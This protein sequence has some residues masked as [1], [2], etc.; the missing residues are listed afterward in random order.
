MHN[1]NKW[2]FLGV[3]PLTSLLSIAGT[4]AYYKGQFPK[5]EQALH[6]AKDRYEAQIAQ[7][8]EAHKT[9]LEKLKNVQLGA[10]NQKAEI[11]QELNRTFNEKYAQLKAEF[12]KEVDQLQAELERQ[13]ATAK[14]YAAKIAEALKQE[15]YSRGK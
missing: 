12:Q 10:E 3:I 4:R 6:E 5:I 1:T 13:K 11:R 15:R 8:R 9:D 7:L 14:E 2:L